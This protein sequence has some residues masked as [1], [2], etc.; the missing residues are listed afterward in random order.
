M[1][2]L[3][4]S[5]IAILCALVASFA[6]TLNDVGIKFAA[7]DYPLHEVVMARAAIGAVLI[8]FIVMPLE[9]GFH[10]IKTK[11][12]PMHLARGALVVATN[13][14][15]FL[16]IAV[17]PLSE[18]TAIFFI[19]PL[20]ITLFSVI[21]LKEQVGPWRW[22][23]I[24]IGFIGVI[25]MFRPT[26]AT[27]QPAAFLPMAAAVCYASIHI[28]TR[29]M[30]NTERASTL[31]FYIQI[32]FVVFGLCMGLAFGKGQIE[33]GDSVLWT[34]LFRP[35]VWPP[36]SDL[37][38]F[39]AI[40]VAS[41]TGGYMISQ[42][43]RMGEAAIV[44]PFEYTGL[45]LAVIGGIVFCGEWPDAVGWAGMALIL[46]SGLIMLWRERRVNKSVKRPL[47]RNRP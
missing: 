47:P 38:I 11:R 34:F 2:K 15:F 45:V 39:G 17:L 32:V 4:A 43:Y 42:A 29:I 1:A 12:L 5:T 26:P 30:G 44:A 6:F 9:G 25:I 21:F 37:A 22:F 16:G 14:L 10:H 27:F 8:F 35:W 19:A 36:M 40:G 41:A 20:F 13:S 33:T 28:L 3:S 46:C 23:A 24:V 7:G 31:A 18:V